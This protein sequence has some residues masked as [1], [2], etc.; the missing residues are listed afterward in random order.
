MNNFREGC[1][2]VCLSLKSPEKAY[3]EYASKIEQSNKLKRSYLCYYMICMTV[4]LRNSIL[5]DQNNFEKTRLT[6]KRFPMSL[7]LKIILHAKRNLRMYSEWIL[8]SNGSQKV[9]QFNV[10]PSEEIPNFGNL[11]F[12]YSTELN[13]VKSWGENVKQFSTIDCFKN[14]SNWTITWKEISSV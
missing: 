9:V 3:P 7:V 6:L 13:S 4:L 10:F 1:F 12:I 11:Q 2:F 5:S 14:R 8:D